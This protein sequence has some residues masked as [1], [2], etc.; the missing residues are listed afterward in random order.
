MKYPSKLKLLAMPPESLVLNI[1][2]I[3]HYDHP[4]IIPFLLASN[5]LCSP[6]IEKHI[7]ILLYIVIP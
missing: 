1:L 2:M 3:L 4:I 6:G 5:N 7:N